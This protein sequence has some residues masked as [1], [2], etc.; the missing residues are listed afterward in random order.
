MAASLLLLKKY[1]PDKTLN[2]LQIQ[3]KYM[4]MTSLFIFFYWALCIFFS[5]YLGNMADFIYG[6]LNG[7]INTLTLHQI[8][9]YSNKAKLVAG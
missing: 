7:F 6:S 3:R 8:I 5:G 9:M 4:I 2:T 1:L